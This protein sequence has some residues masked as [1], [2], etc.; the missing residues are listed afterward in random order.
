MEAYWRQT[1]KE[2]LAGV[3]KRGE[4]AMG[5]IRHAGAQHSSVSKLLRFGKHIKIFPAYRKVVFA[6]RVETSIADRSCLK[7]F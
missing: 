7:R 4:G 5:A 1:A 3:E 2:G 6:V